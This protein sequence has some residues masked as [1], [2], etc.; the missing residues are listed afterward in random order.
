MSDA[1]DPLLVELARKSAVCWLTYDGAT[2]P[3]WH[4]WHV[5]ALLV[6]SDGDEQPLPGLADAGRV[7]VTLRS[8]HSGGRL[9]TWVSLP[10]PVPPEDP[11]AWAAATAALL[12]ARL[13]LPDHAAAVTDWA[14]RSRVTRLVPTGEVLARP[15]SLPA[16]PHLAEPRP[17]PATTSGRPPRVLHRRQRQRRRLS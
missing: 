4:V 3:A 12:P 13:N 16:G 1:P 5:D 17:S 2:R 10:E 6:L 11:E 8:R 9:L 7:E 14:R 15:G